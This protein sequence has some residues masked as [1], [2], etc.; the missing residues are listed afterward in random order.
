MRRKPLSFGLATTLHTPSD[1]EADGWRKI[2]EPERHERDFPQPV[3]IGTQPTET[4]RSTELVRLAH[5]GIDR[6]L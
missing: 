1:A 3:L 2:L 6:W 5:F 4:Q